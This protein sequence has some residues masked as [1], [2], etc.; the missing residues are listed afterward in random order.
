MKISTLLLCATLL[1]TTQVR[2]ADDCD[3]LTDTAINAALDSPDSL[4]DL[5]VAF[6]VGECVKKDYS[7]A[8]ILWRKAANLGVIPA[9]NN[10]G[11]LNSQGLGIPKNEA[12]AVQLWREAALAG[13]SESQVHLG[14][15]IFHGN[16]IA[17]NQVEGLAWILFA[18][19]SSTHRPDTPNGGGGQAIHEMAKTSRD[20]MLIKA[21]LVLQP[22][23]ALKTSLP[24]HE[25]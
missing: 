18:V 17:A 15:A 14:E 13:H 16:G 19:E 20:E 23:E 7:Q 10:L 9:K 6:Y 21:P 3:N 5:G 24:V 8:A 22:A 2:A 12:M 1:A 25:R 11:Y 4:Y